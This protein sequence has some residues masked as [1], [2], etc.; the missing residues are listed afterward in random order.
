MKDK[1]SKVFKMFYCGANKIVQLM[2]AI[3]LQ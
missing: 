1:K 3:L 2:D